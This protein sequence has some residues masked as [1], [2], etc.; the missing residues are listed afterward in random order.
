MSKCVCC[1]SDKELN[2]IVYER[3]NIEVCDECYKYLR[4]VQIGNLSPE[5][6]I[7][8]NSTDM[9]K[10]FVTNDIHKVIIHDNLEISS[11]STDYT[12]NSAAAVNTIGIIVLI[13]SIMGGLGILVY[14]LMA[15]YLSWGIGLLIGGGTI[16][17]GIFIRSLSTCI[18]IITENQYRE[19]VKRK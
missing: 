4:D 13:A 16:I 18:S 8:E 9:F 1:G 5:D 15:P 2:T 14:S 7:T 10:Y 12:S 19:L 3:G 17:S 6:I 11:I